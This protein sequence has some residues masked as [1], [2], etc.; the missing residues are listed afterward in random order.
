MA[1]GVIQLES[2][3]NDVW[4]QWTDTQKLK[5]ANAVTPVISFQA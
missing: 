5:L 2:K 1:S 3:G 4:W